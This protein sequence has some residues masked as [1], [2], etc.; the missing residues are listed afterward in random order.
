[1]NAAPTQYSPTVYGVIHTV[2]DANNTFVVR[3]TRLM[4][5]MWLDSCRDVIQSQQVYALIDLPFFDLEIFS[6]KQFQL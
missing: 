4:I 5:R 2:T 6:S 1:M 3:Y